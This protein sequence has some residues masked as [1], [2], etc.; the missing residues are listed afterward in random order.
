MHSTAQHST[1]VGA[2]LWARRA[3]RDFERAVARDDAN[4]LSSCAADLF[5]G[6]ENRARSKEFSYRALHSL[7]QSVRGS[8]PRNVPGSANRERRARPC[9]LEHAAIV[10]LLVL[11]EHRD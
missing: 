8:T 11:L 4:V 7:I 2:H 3:E 6:R 1:H 10:H 9:V 5:P